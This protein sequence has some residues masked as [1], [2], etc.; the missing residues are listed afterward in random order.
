MPKANFA[1]YLERTVNFLTDMMRNDEE[2]KKE[3]FRRSAE[4]KV[5]Q[6]KKLCRVAVSSVS[7]AACAVIIFS[8][9]IPVMKVKTKTV[10]VE[11]EADKS[12]VTYDGFSVPS[13]LTNIYIMTDGIKYAV[14][15]SSDVDIIMKEIGKLDFSVDC[16]GTLVEIDKE[17]D[18]RDVIEETAAVADRERQDQCLG[19]TCSDGQ[20]RSEIS[21]VIY[22]YDAEYVLREN[23]LT[24]S[25]GR[26]VIL[27][28]EQAKA[29]LD[30][31]AKER[32]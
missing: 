5:T 17:A 28:D 19:E 21:C 26:S 6:R 3:I 13:L 27:S 2:F 24:S 8:A 18:R 10:P 15:D 14:T 31:A 4:F 20:I 30:I 12:A 7:A 32:R 23:T 1:L 16:A 25:D 9:M 11:K 29:I 22:V